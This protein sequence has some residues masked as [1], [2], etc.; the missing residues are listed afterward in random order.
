MRRFRSQPMNRFWLI[1]RSCLL[2]ALVI[3][4]FLLLPHASF[5]QDPALPSGKS[6]PLLTMEDVPT[7]NPLPSPDGLPTAEEV[8]AMG[9]GDVQASLLG[10]GGG[11]TGTIRG[12]LRAIP[13][14]GLGYLGVQT[15]LTNTKLVLV[16]DL[17]VLKDGILPLSSWVRVKTSLNLLGITI[18]TQVELD[19]YE[20]GQ[21][22][23]RLANGVSPSTIAQRYNIQAKE[24]WLAS[25][26]IHLFLTP[27]PDADIN[28]LINLMVL[29]PDIIWAELNYIGTPLD[30]NPYRSWGWGG[31]DPGNYENQ[32]AFSQVNIDPALQQYDGSG[33]T[34]AIL[35]TGIDR[36]HPALAGHW[37]TGYD[38]VA[39]D[40]Q[41]Q[42]EGSGLAWG[43]GTHIAGIIAQIAPGSKILPVRV[44]DSNGRGNTFTLAYAIEW[45]VNQG[46]DVINLSLGTPYDSQILRE[47]VAWAQAQGVSL[48]AAAG[49]S[50]SNTLQYPAGYAGVLSVTAITESDTKAEFA[51]YGGWIKLSTP[52]VGIISTIVG[53]NG[54]GY[55]TWSGTSM[56]TPFASGALALARQQAPER[57][58]AELLQM[59][60]DHAQNLNA[61]NPQ[62][63][64][65]LGG[66]LDVGVA[67]AE[68]GN[69]N[70]AEQSMTNTTLFLPFT[71]AAP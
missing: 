58:P 14:L 40:A 30:G 67:L 31:Q 15:D 61:A 33:V 20:P 8:L 68:A 16:L 26:N 53:P 27:S 6:E 55:A 62:F 47:T 21:V 17:G 46:A 42:D 49:N 23:V 24:T 5:A 65:Q 70:S 1:A 51:N 4:P 56:A 7:L 32:T 71:M 64:D 19:D 48:V 57:T 69:V 63:V 12:L 28:W 50:N 41:P 60:T 2:S 3:I 54:S 45:A 43:H 35:D 25:G 44:L 18:A 10:G 52:G 37:L 22:V 39:D 34:I 29:D 38:M 9:E 11:R 13:L 36:N 66:L 59:L